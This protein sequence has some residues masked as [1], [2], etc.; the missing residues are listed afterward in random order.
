[1]FGKSLRHIAYLEDQW[2][3]LL[4]WQA[5]AFKLGAR[6]RWIDWRAEQQFSRLHLIANNVRF[7]I[8]SQ[9]QVR[10][11][12]SWVLSTQSLQIHQPCMLKPLYA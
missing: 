1:M 9:F 8:L 10:Y 3:A 7:V 5:G 12:A 4:G 2:L 6:D 11:L